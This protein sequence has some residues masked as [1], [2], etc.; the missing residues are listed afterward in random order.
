MRSSSERVT[1][2]SVQSAGA[3]QPWDSMSFHGASYRLGPIRLEHVALPA[4][5]A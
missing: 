2:T 3:I 5:L 4:V 1:R